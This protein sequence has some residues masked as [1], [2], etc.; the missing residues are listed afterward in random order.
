MA[1]TG[2]KSSKNHPPKQFALPADV[3]ALGPAGAFI[4]HSIRN[5]VAKRRNR[6]QK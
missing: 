5:E 1:A 2:E 3:R 4:G 6:K